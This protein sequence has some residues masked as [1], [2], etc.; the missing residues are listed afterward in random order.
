MLAILDKSFVSL[1]IRLVIHKSD[2]WTSCLTFLGIDANTIVAELRFP[3]DKLLRLSTL[4]N[5]WADRKTCSR[6]ELESL[7]NLLNRPCKVI[8][9]GHSFHRRILHLKWDAT[10]TM[11][12][13][14]QPGVLFR[15]G[16]VEYLDPVLEWCIISFARIASHGNGIRR[17]QFMGVRS[18]ALFRLVSVADKLAPLPIM[19]K[20]LFPNLLAMV[21]WD[22]S[23]CN[24]RINSHI[25]SCTSKHLHCMYMLRNLAFLEARH[26]FIM[27][28]VFIDIHINHLA[29]AL[30]QKFPPTSS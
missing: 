30:F 15:P 28:A 27:H 22:P 1:D 25:R 29:N 13:P 8:C 26:S 7:L 17:L 11:P 14:P 12:H 3:V 16:M 18:L 9:T 20:E 5:Q 2:S 23:W 21:V 19:V 4:L 24:H 10:R 6:W